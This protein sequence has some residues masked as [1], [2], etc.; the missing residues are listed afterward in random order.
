MNLTPFRGSLKLASGRSL[1]CTI[2]PPA[3]FDRHKKYPLV[4]GYTVIDM[5]T[6]GHEQFWMQDLAA[7]G[8]FV[9]FADRN[10]WFKD[11]EK[12][13][14][15]VMDIYQSLSQDP[16]IDTGRVYLFAASAETPYLSQCLTHSPGLWK[17]AIFVSPTGL[18]DF[19][20]AP[21]FQTR[22]RILLTGGSE[23]HLVEQRKAFQEKA[24]Q[25]G[26]TVD[27]V[28]HPGEIHTILGN[29]ARLERIT[30]IMHFIFEE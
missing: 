15:T 30:A 4:L 24:L 17:G 22:P 1:N 3:N 14:P 13:E 2:Y 12:W 5:T 25:W 20:K 29:N 7:C 27:V 6:E 16:C 23:D 26:V 10:R 9:A 8:A 28:N 19:S 21:F 11:I 18:P